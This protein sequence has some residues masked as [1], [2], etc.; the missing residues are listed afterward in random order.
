MKGRKGKKEKGKDP[1]PE[2][3]LVRNKMTLKCTEY[4]G[5]PQWSSGA[6]KI[7]TYDDIGGARQL[8]RS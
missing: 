7:D 6:E 8:F 4:W 5:V 3:I 2:K 1:E